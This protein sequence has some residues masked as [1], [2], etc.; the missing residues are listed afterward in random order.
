M[1]LGGAKQQ[2]ARAPGAAQLLVLEAMLGDRVAGQ[3]TLRKP[4]GHLRAAHAERMQ[5]ASRDNEQ[6]DPIDA[7]VIEPVADQG[8]ALEGC[9]LDVVDSDRHPAPGGRC[10]PRRLHAWASAEHPCRRLRARVHR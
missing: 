4:A 6:S 8:A 9:R 3:P 2:P 1:P 10:A 5:V 7:V